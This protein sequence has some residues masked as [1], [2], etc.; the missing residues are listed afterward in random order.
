MTIIEKIKERIE[1]AYYYRLGGSLFGAIESNPKKSYRCQKDGLIPSA[2]IDWQ[3][4]EPYCPHCGQ[5]LKTSTGKTAK[6]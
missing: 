3:G 1:Y 4:T 2:E 5:R 6:V